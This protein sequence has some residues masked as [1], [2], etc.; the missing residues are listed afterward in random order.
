MGCASNH[1]IKPL[2]QLCHLNISRWTQYSRPKSVKILS[3]KE[4]SAS[5]QGKID[6]CFNLSLKENTST[7]TGS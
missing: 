3:F 2:N 1:K 5:E 6:F 7:K 4:E